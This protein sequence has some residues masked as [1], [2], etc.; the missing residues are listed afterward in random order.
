MWEHGDGE[1]PQ[2]T[3]P[4]ATQCGVDV[5]VLCQHRREDPDGERHPGGDHHHRGHALFGWNVDRKHSERLP[6][7]SCRYMPTRGR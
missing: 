7:W 4:G 2:S 5:D 3:R 1:D 6:W